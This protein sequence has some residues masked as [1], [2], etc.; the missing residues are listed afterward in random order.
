MPKEI[1]GRDFAFLP[2]AQLLTFD[3]ITR[4]ARAFAR[5]RV[6]KVRLTVGEPAA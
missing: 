5:E 4:M 2:E 1:F 3:E 6:S